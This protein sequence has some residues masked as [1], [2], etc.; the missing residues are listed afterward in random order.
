MTPVR[1]MNR[2]RTTTTRSLAGWVWEYTIGGHQVIKK[3]L[4]YREHGLLGRELRPAEARE[5]RD[6]ARRIAAMLLLQAKLDAN[7]AVVNA[8]D[9]HCV[10]G[11]KQLRCKSIRA[12]CATG[13][14][15]GC[16]RRVTRPMNRPALERRLV[17][18]GANASGLDGSPGSE[19]TAR[20]EFKISANRADG[21]WGGKNG[22]G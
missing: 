11:S 17:A 13:L 10:L 1:Y 5:V 18:I 8:N 20:V 3:W 21:L 6:I 4:S 12:R 14:R 19:Q 7:Y 22:D 9:R 2:N 16:S 15:V